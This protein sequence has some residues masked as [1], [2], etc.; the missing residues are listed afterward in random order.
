MGAKRVLGTFVMGS[1]AALALSVGTVDAQGFGSGLYASA[2]GGAGFLPDDHFTIKHGGFAYDS[3][4]TSFDGGLMGGAALGMSLAPSWRV[5]G[6]V[7]YRHNAISSYYEG[8][9]TQNLAQSGDHMSAFALMGNIWYDVPLFRSVD[10]HVGGGVGVARVHL[11]FKNINP[12][13]RLSTSVDDSDFV[14]AGQLGA[15][16]AWRLGNGIKL[17]TDY[18][19]MATGDATFTG[20]YNGGGSFTMTKNYTSHAVTVGLSVPLGG[21]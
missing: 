15:G 2:F 18:R 6:E 10:L 17:T 20:H 16:L 12:N 11:R 3:D 13:P 14:A 1:V 4:N 19:F 9:G 8:G 5:E 7:S 21:N